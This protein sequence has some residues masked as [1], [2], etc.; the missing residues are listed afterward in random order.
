V[1]LKFTRPE[2]RV[3][4]DRERLETIGISATDV[5]GTLQT[6]LGAQ[7]VGYF[8]RNGRQYEVVQQIADAFRTDS[9]ILGQLTVR[10]PG[11]A[12]ITLDNLVN[13]HESV[14]APQR[15]RFDRQVSATVSGRLAPGR[16]LAEGI[17]AMTRAAAALP[18]GIGT[19]FAGNARD[20]RESGGSLFITFTIALV[21][22]FL[23]LAA[24]FESWRAPLAIMLTVPLALAGALLALW[25]CGQTIN[26]FSQIGMIMLVGLVTKNGILLVDFAQQ[27]QQAGISPRAAVLEAADIRLRPILMTTVATLFGVLPIALAL[28]AGAESRTSMGIGVIGGL[29]IGSVLTLYVIPAAYLILAGRAAVEPPAEAIDDSPANAKA[30]PA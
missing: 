2:L 13:V 10:A 11:G 8:N 19:T 29:L 4:L 9:T 22:V 1:D 27:R 12:L 25:A 16:T 26:I 5:A 23:V 18:P 3:S 17:H 24:Q 14:A 20:F 30:L 21:F 15:Y 6:S 28:G 7:R